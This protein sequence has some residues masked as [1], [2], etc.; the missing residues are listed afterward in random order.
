MLT[1]LLACGPKQAPATDK[2]VQPTGWHS[3]DAWSGSCFGAPDFSTMSTDGARAKR[4][5]TASAMALQWRGERNDGV[6]FD[7]DL[8]DHVEQ[9]L[10]DDPGQVDEVAAENLA[11]CGQLMRGDVGTMAWG[12]WLEDLPDRLQAGKCVQMVDDPVYHHIELGKIWQ[13]P[14]AL[15]PGESVRISAS[16]T[17]QYRT[18]E[19]GPW[20]N[21]AGVEGEPA[22]D[23]PCLAEGARPGM[24]VARFGESCFPVGLD[25]SFT[26]PTAGTLEVALNDGS[27]SDNAW[28]QVEL[29][30]DRI[31][32]EVAPNG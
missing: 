20:I 7:R 5:A 32:V 29:V 27:P 11:F 28:R 3:L 8:V 22:A 9:L 2:P 13:F 24:L 31:S 15:C 14:V 21:A 18:S 30:Q 6:R 26:A 25:L 4:Q 1:L 10:R 17:D 19:D 16:A 12:A 23:A